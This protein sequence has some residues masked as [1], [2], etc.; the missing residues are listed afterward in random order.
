MGRNARSETADWKCVRRI[1]R[2]S[3][4]S[5][6][7]TCVPSGYFRPP[8]PP[9]NY[10]NPPGTGAAARRE[11]RSP[12]GGGV[13]SAVRPRARAGVRTIILLRVESKSRGDPFTR[14]RCNVVSRADYV[15]RLCSRRTYESAADGDDEVAPCR[16]TRGRPIGCRAEERDGAETI[17]I[18][19]VVRDPWGEI[20]AENLVTSADGNFPV[21]TNV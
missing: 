14:P 3:R 20:A 10:A 18:I 12:G 21:F 19:A 2:C 15:Y 13:F 16:T 4:F 17:Q 7:E 9:R 6:T 8:I 1:S 5:E 11:T